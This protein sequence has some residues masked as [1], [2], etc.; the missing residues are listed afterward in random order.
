MIMYM[1]YI[2]DRPQAPVNSLE[3]AKQ[4][5]AQHIEQSL[6]IVCSAAPAASQIWTY[7]PL[8]KD[9]VE[10]IGGTAKI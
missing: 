1:L 6:K 8:K 5:A 7:D 4:L 10:Q 3:E 9:W 2:N